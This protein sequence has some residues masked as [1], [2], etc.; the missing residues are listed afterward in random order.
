MKKM[1]PG[2]LPRMNIADIPSNTITHWH[3]EVV[4][5]DMVDYAIDVAYALLGIPRGQDPRL[6]YLKHSTKLHP[7][8]NN[9]EHA[10]VR[11]QLLLCAY[12]MLVRN[13]QKI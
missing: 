12:E 5:E 3:R 8:K 7:D 10:T 11:F 2:P 6:A 4:R 9:D 13:K 1:K